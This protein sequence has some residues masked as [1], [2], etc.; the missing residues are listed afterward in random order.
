MSRLSRKKIE[1][2]KSL[3]SKGYSLPE[4]GKALGI[5][6]TTVFYHIKNVEI[7][8]GFI[9]EWRGKRGGSKK[10][11]LIKEK[12]AFEEGKKTIDKLS[13][14][15][16][17]LFLAALYW[18]EGNKTDFILTNSDP[19]LIMV[20]IDGLRKILE[21]SDDRIQVTLRLYEDIDKEKSLSFW[22][23]VVKIPKEKFLNIHILPGKKKGKLEYGMCRV[24]V[25]KGGDLLKKI[26]GIN[27]AIVSSLLS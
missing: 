17:L 22:S 12:L 3:R 26:F 27:K 15:E 16:K 6:K 25:K 8:P 2:I 23:E 20:F 11:K 4:I 18:A 14:K 10:L 24:R 19:N 1:K 9:S 21:V 7:L 5:G 13:N